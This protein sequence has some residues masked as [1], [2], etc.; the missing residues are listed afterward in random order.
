MLKKQQTDWEKA[1]RALCAYHGQ[2]E[3]TMHNGRPMWMSYLAE[4][5]A[6]LMAIGRFDEPGREPERKA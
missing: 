6:V 3:N 4:A 2:P 1:A 5:K